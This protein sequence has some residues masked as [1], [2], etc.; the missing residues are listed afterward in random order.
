MVLTKSLGAPMNLFRSPLNKGCQQ[1]QGLRGIHPLS[2]RPSD[3]RGPYQNGV[4]HT[5]AHITACGPQPPNGDS[6]NQHQLQ[7]S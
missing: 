4:Y 1:N 2:T 6:Y 5:P 3:E 7:R